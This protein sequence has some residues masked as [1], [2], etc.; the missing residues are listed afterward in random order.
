[1]ASR[2]EY[3]EHDDLAAASGLGSLHNFL[4]FWGRV[5]TR[6]LP[7]SSDQLVARAP[8]PPRPCPK[9][10]ARGEDF[11]PL[12]SLPTKFLAELPARERAPRPPTPPA[13]RAG[14]ASGRVPIVFVDVDGEEMQVQ[15]EIGDTLLDVA[16]ENDIEIEGPPRRTA[17]RPCRKRPLPA[18]ARGSI[19]A[20]G[21]GGHLA[22]SESPRCAG[23]C[24][25]ECACSTCHIILEKEVFDALEAPTEEEEDMLDLA[26]GLTDT[27]GRP[28]APPPCRRL[29]SLR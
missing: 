8:G 13:S 11:L 23:A 14:S 18:H 28:P 2:R 15:A 10:R 3:S 20:A 21:W 7:L 16:H 25:G 27:C 29:V 9:S 26:L 6:C 1:M 19:R 12:V 4:V 17:T 22:L 5:V 24:G